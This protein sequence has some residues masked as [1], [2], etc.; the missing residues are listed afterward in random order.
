MNLSLS[1][2]LLSMLIVD[3]GKSLLAASAVVVEARWLDNGAGLGYS[4]AS[5]R[6]VDGRVAMG[7]IE[8]KT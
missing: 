8:C 1:P 4:L 5:G 6:V 7:R 2:F 3:A